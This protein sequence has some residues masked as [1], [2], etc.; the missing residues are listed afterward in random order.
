MYWSI[1]HCI[2]ALCRVQQ[3]RRALHQYDPHSDAND[4][5]DDNAADDG[6]DPVTPTAPCP[7]VDSCTVL[8][9]DARTTSGV[10][11]SCGRPT[12]ATALLHAGMNPALLERMLADDML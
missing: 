4:N 12:W 1:G 7:A 11:P 9:P 10:T 8:A 5:P 6:H 3:W 2:L